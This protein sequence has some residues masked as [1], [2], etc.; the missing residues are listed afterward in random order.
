MGIKGFDD[1]KAD[2]KKFYDGTQVRGDGTRRYAAYT[3]YTGTG[4]RGQ[5]GYTG[6]VHGDRRDVFRCF[7]RQPCS[8]ASTRIS[9]VA[10][11]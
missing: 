1:L 7:S 9:D 8:I 3:R 11:F 10:F 4:T 2:E 5:T 6:T